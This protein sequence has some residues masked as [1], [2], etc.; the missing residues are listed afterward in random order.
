[1]SS[2]VET[3]LVK[4]ILCMCIYVMSKN[5]TYAG[6]WMGNANGESQHGPDAGPDVP[7]LS[8]II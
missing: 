3:V 4:E 1:M 6:C 5:I 2:E 7:R 8:V